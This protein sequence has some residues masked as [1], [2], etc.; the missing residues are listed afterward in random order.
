METFDLKNY[1]VY[2]RKIGRGSF[3]SV[4]KGYNKINNLPV[5]VKKINDDIVSKMKK[6]IKR[7][8]EVM[9]K[10][11]H[12]NILKL[13]EVIYENNNIYLVLEYCKYGDLSFFL[14]KNR[15][16]EPQVKNFLCQI[17]DGLKYLHN[18]N[19]F[20]RD[21]KPQNILIDR[22]LNL[23]ITDFSFAKEDNEENLSQTMCGSPLY[24]APEILN[25]Q[26]YTNKTDLWS[27]GVIMYELIV[28][29]TP[30]RAKNIVNLVKNIRNRDV[31]IPK[32]IHIS[33][34]CK[35]LLF[36][37]LEKDPDKRITW[38]NFFL[39]PWIQKNK[40]KNTKLYGELQIDSNLNCSKIGSLSKSDTFLYLDNKKKCSF[41]LENNTSSIDSNTSEDS[42]KSKSSF[43]NSEYKEDF[44][45]F[46]FESDILESEKKETQY[47][48]KNIENIN[49][50]IKDFNDYNNDYIL[51][52]SPPKN[53][54]MESQ[55]SYFGNI[56]YTSYDV[57]KKSIYS[58][59]KNI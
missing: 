19:I 15:L 55:N 31:I 57:L 51:I 43:C 38:K 50:N 24:M 34:N 9:K 17:V 11:K 18:F 26:E 25:Y 44:L 56:L 6:Y 59:T 45:I 14:K 30:Y 22:N 3:S 32:N 28:G 58:F 21:L 39:H 48:N 12:K 27:I 5:A 40:K 23:K 46:P 41:N 42:E 33:S 16:T 4:Y 10:L 29:K 2:K 52:N 53:L 7:E 13:Y 20:H 1:K 36:S 37:L 47:E 49:N 35:H 54:T 8:I